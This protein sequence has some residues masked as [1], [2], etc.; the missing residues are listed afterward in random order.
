MVITDRPL[1]SKAKVVH[2]LTGRP[3]TNNVQAPQ[4]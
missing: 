2:A 4:T 1:T 3:S